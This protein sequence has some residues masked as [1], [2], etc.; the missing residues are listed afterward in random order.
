MTGRRCW[1][2]L[3]LAALSLSAGCALAP[4]SF[5]QSNDPAP[6]VRARSMSLGRSQPESVVVPALIARLSDPDAVVRMTA[7]EELKR[8]T[9]QDFHY[10]PWEDDQGRAQSTLAWQNW[11]K[12]KQSGVY[13]S[14]Q[15]ASR[16]PVIEGSP[17]QP[18]RKRRLFGN[19]R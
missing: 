14:P 9:G 3:S 15:L 11:W 12:A 19:F 16:R 1:G 4:K 6:L 13:A 10:E 8:R 5:V 2:L 17:V 7:S 18:K